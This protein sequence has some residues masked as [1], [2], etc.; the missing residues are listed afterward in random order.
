MKKFIYLLTALAALNL[1]GQVC[2]AEIKTFHAESSYRMDKG[3]PI[4]IAQETAFNEAIRKISEEASVAIN[5]L[6]VSRDSE[7]EFDR[8]E[9]FTAAILRVKSKTFGKEFTDD[10]GL[11]ITVTVDAE[12]DTDNAAELLNELREARNSAKNY[13][14]VLKNYTERKNNF[15]TVY[16]EYLGSYQKR[17][18]RKIRDGC[19]LEMEG[20]L[21]EALNLYDA[22]I[23]ESVANDAELSLAYVKR[24]FV[25]AM[26][27]KAELAAVGFEKALSLN[28]D[29]IGVHYV[30]AVMA[31]TSGNKIQ[32]AQEYRAFVK[33]A[34]IVYYDVEIISAPDRIV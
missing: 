24:G 26:Q 18:M 7:L 33:D 5:R 6:S 20:K 15:N 30:K 28:N 11:K 9:N 16:G 14:E 21:D 27:N 8:I 19:K 4:K 12:I 32:A 25:Y 23:A 29:A 2:S 34:D 13:E 10:G 31:E 22:A 3:E 17:I 1:G